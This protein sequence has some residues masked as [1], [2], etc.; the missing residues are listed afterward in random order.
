MAGMLWSEYK[1]RMGCSQGISMQFD[2]GRILQKRDDL[3]ELTKPFETKEMDEVIKEMPVDRAPGSDGF[4]GMFLKKCWHIVKEDFYKLA[5]DFHDESIQL[6]NIN[7]SYITLVP[8]KQVS[9]RSSKRP[10]VIL[11]LDFAKAFDTIEHEAI[12]KVME[13][14]GFNKKWINWAKAIMSSDLLQS[15]VND[16]VL[17][18][19]LSRPIETSDEDFPIVQYADDTLL[20]LP[21][22]EGQLLALKETLQKFSAST[23]RQNAFYISG[24]AF[25]YNKANNYRIITTVGLTKQ[26]DRIL[27][28]CLWRD[29]EGEPKQSLA[30][31]E[32]ICKPKLKGGLGIV[33]F[34]KQ[35][36]ALLIK[37]LDKFYNKQ[38]L[39]W[40]Q[41]MGSL[42]HRPLS[43]QAY[44]EL[45]ELQDIMQ[46][47]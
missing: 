38:D 10:I 3:E 35:N 43:L 25:G 45:V 4:N 20:I 6:A 16:M 5:A 28:Q 15:A 19:T 12:L 37:F 31:W 7:G 17:Q 47:S 18:G 8:K 36:A 33:D 46:S 42:F 41:E 22:D 13:F 1:N 29:K 9:V 27:R 34:Q 23:G 2:L 39:P 14:K 26:L 32:M 30:A 11:K 24:S 21:A 44:Q 40:V